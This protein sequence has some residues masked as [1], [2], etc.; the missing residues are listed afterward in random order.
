MLEHHTYARH[1][2]MGLNNFRNA[3]L[4]SEE[5]VI[6]C[7]LVPGRGFRGKS[8]DQV[9]KFAE[10]VKGVEEIH[11]LS[12]TDNAGG[13]PALLADVLGTEIV[14]MGVD[15]IVHFSCKDMNRNSIESRAYALQRF[16]ITNLLVITGDY[17]I[18][19]FLGLP[20]PV[21]DIDSVSALHYLS[22]MNRGLEISQGSK[23]ITLDATDLFLGA[24]VSPFKWTEGPSKMQYLKM[25]KKLQTGAHYFIT[26]LGFD[27]R[28]NVEL[29]RFTRDYLKS[30]IP[31]I[32]SVYILS[33]GAARIMH[34]GEIPGC[35]VN[36]ELLNTIKSEARAEDRG[37]GSR[38]E[39]AARQIAILK[40][41]GYN[42]A[43]IEGLNLRAKD[44]RW[45]LERAGDIGDNWEDHFTEFSFS[46]PSPYYLFV[47]GEKFVVPDSDDKIEFKR[48]KKRFV[49]SPVF[50]MTRLLHIM[51][52]EPKSLGYKFMRVLSRI[53]QRNHLLYRIFT[54]LEKFSKEILFSCRHCD[55][56]ALFE[57]YYICPESH[58]PKGMRIGACG[59]SRV[60]GHCEV[61]AEKKCI[62]D[63]IYH[64]ASSLGQCDKL[65]F[66]IPPRDW[67]LYDTNSWV[68][69]F[70]GY[71]HAA[72]KIRLPVPQD[73]SI[74]D[75]DN[76]SKKLVGIG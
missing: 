13:N 20:Q 7:E 26:Q 30:K 39:R 54:I 74:C 16:G 72:K 38:L 56:C 48:P 65:R 33:S 68:N 63:M 64:R 10:E 9:L 66:I 8:V 73:I 21:F 18:G 42:G 6:T 44:V 71:D 27:M 46:P 15:L 58:C 3:L 53:L 32:G 67:E 57:L 50:W 11:A 59:G 45:I 4:D 43:H 34:E 2:E 49:F 31:L 61:F 51:I 19:G 52:F 70:L 69:Y 55:D 35:Y 47:G 24:V 23:E 1:G 28:K 22:E 29:L 62:W 5:F 37:K 36:N 14:A 12:L 41:L 40:G 60:N 17:P 76:S 25:E 75:R